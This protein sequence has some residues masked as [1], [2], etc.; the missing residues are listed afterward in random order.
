MI[1]PLMGH[2]LYILYNM[3]TYFYAMSKS[4]TTSDW[5]WEMIRDGEPE[6]KVA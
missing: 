1:N 2:M 5:N 4:E 6:G 3:K